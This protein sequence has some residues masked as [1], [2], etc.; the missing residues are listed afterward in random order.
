M[1]GTSAHARPVG[2]APTASIRSMA[3]RGTRLVRPITTTGSPVCPLVASQAFA[4]SYA[5]DLEIRS[6]RAA[7]SILRNGGSDSSIASLHVVEGLLGWW[8][9]L[10]AAAQRAADAG[11]AG[12][13]RHG[14]T[15]Q[16]R[17]C[18][19]SCHTRCTGEID[20][21][22]SPARTGVA[23]PP[24]QN[25]PR[26]EEGGPAPASSA[27]SRFERAVPLRGT[28]NRPCYGIRRRYQCTCALHVGSM[29]RGGCH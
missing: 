22:T 17:C 5:A 6:R 12:R 19:G 24:L 20:A 1:R 11:R 9:S 26:T 16:G 3:A 29:R 13:W 28:P 25:P 2:S 23:H 7:S 10:A 27:A 4:C 18:H 14:S 21:A 8:A 15:L